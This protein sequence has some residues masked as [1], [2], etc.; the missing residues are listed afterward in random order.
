[1]D[2]TYLLSDLQIQQ[3][4]TNGYLQLYVDC[5]PNFHQQ[6]Y[7]QIESMFAGEGNV[8]NNILP[9]VPKIQQVFD[10]PVLQGALISL[11]GEGYTMN[12]HRHCHLN[13]PSGGG[14]RWHKDCYVFDH[15]IRH[16]RFHWVLAFYYPQDTDE[17]M[18]PT[19]LLPGMHFCK[20][21]SSDDPEHATEPEVLLCGKAGTVT[22]V[23][24]DAWHRATTNR[25]T[26][27]RYMLK[28]QFARMQEPH[29]PSWNHQQKTWK[30]EQKN[31]VAED[32]W[33]WLGG[34]TNPIKNGSSWLNLINAMK[35][36]TLDSIEETIAKTPDN[37]H[38]TNPTAGEAAQKLSAIGSSTVPE[39]TEVLSNPHWWVRA[40]AV[41]ILTKIG[42]SAE[43]AIPALAERTKDDHWW[44]RRNAIEALGTIGSF[45]SSTVK[46]LGEKLADP[47]YRVR[48]NAAIS[49][50]KSGSQASPVISMLKTTLNDED[51]YN[52][53]Y[54]ALALRRIDTNPAKDALLN[55]LFTARWCPITT[56]DNLY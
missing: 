25:S 55:A 45:D 24:F 4:I 27:K 15:N 20:S 43:V 14:Q 29:K 30:N 2:S 23:H 34:G 40:V 13:A 3:F 48:R 7:Q 16:P 38:G 11:L 47:D 44:V 26:K 54:A 21:I 8:G 37:L 19:A 51:R 31:E 41:D 35:K 33:N 46:L 12:P 1:M 42:P 6:I 39:L 32:V 28:F 52:R 53:F 5:G 36:E 10:H 18:G 50:A 9:R 56:A 49:L 17:D 22:L